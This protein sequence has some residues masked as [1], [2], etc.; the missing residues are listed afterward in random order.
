MG[1]VADAVDAETELGKR[2]GGGG[3]VER[4]RE[5]QRKGVQL[6]V[7]L[8]K[9]RFEERNTLWDEE[10]GDAEEWQAAEERA[11]IERERLNKT[12]GVDR[13]CGRRRESGR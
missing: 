9:G 1:E 2:G 10:E 11:E 5:W 13:S 7:E 3:E 6:R 4:E 8:I 12:S